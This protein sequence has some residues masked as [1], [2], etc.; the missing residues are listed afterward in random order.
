MGVADASRHNKRATTMR[1]P[2]HMATPPPQ[3]KP[4]LRCRTTWL[5]RRQSPP[6][7]TADARDAPAA[8]GRRGPGST[9]PTARTGLSAPAP[10]RLCWR[11]R[12]S[13]RRPRR[14]CRQGPNRHHGALDAVAANRRRLQAATTR[15]QSVQ[16]A[17]TRSRS[18]RL[19]LRLRL[20]PV[21]ARRPAARVAAGA[22]PRKRTR[23]RKLPRLWKRP[24]HP[25]RRHAGAARGPPQLARM[26]PERPVG[27]NE[28]GRRVGAN[29]MRF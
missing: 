13:W 19:R 8:S 23:R 18:Y 28:G 9:N 20:K 22:N 15:C 6:G 26:R 27:T 16:R 10:W 4:S 12:Q 25:N 1:S 11:S 14:L 7:R 2:A 3:A 29:R 24:R 5:R 17:A 21:P